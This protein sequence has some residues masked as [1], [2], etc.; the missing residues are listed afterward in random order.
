MKLPQI[1]IYIASSI[2]GYIA[3][4][5]GDLDWLNFAPNYD[6]DYGFKN[7][8]NQ[9]DTVILGRKTYETA[10]KAYGSSDWPYTGKKIIVLSNTLK[11]V[12]DDANLY[13]G[14]LIKL[15]E[16]LYSEG[17]RHIWIDGGITVSQFLRLNLVDKMILSIIPILLGTG[18]PLFDIKKEI[19]CDLVSTQAYPNG[20]VQIK[21]DMKK[22]KNNESKN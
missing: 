14:N 13:S 21:Y 11:K 15:T 9:I 17:T 20:L 16:Q 19:S 8:I 18:I 6:E 12:I 4:E 10:V 2:D 22:F 5:N 3:K 7:F 1:L